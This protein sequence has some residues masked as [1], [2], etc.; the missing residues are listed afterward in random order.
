MNN[1]IRSSGFVTSGRTAATH[2]ALLTDARNT[3]AE[4]KA[5]TLTVADR[6][7]DADDARL[8]LDAL[9]LLDT[10]GAA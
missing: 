5:A 3:P 6:A 4:R 10:G 2:R 8:I 9:G 7:H 1:D